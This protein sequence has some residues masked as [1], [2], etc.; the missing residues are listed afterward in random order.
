MFSQPLL[1]FFA[2]FVGLSDLKEFTDVLNHFFSLFCRLND[3]K[4]FA[5][6]IEAVKDKGVAVA[7]AS[8]DDVDSAHKTSPGF[9]EVKNAL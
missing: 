2:F 5:D 4:E 6:V 8:P 7:V 3:F 1:F 9:F